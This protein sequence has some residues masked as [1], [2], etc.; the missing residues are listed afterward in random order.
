MVKTNRL[1]RIDDE[2]LRLDKNFQMFFACGKLYIKD[3][4][5][6]ERLFGFSDIIEKEATSSALKIK[7]L[8]IFHDV[9]VFD[10]MIKNLTFARKL[11]NIAKNSPVILNNVAPATILYFCLNHT[12]L[13][14]E[15]KFDKSNSKLLLKSKKEKK[16][17]LKV[18][19]DDLLTSH[20][21][22]IEYDSLAKDPLS[23]N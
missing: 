22:S 3:I 9:N 4:N 16:L 15:F 10:D 5:A 12:P 7:D 17:F 2:F 18:M 11:I 14:G 19:M 21:T 23:V 20:L 1:E 13:Q 6:I 8:D